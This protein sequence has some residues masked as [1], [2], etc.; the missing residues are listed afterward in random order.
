V[1]RPDCPYAPFISS[2]RIKC[3]LTG[4]AY[5]DGIRQFPFIDFSMVASQTPI[6]LSSLVVIV[7]FIYLHPFPNGTPVSLASLSLSMIFLPG[8]SPS[9]DFFSAARLSLIN[10]TG[11]WMRL[12][13]FRL[14]Y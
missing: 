10:F 4:E 3:H 9:F 6:S 14:G 1:S 7:G 5:G 11:F 12:L 13:P 8:L 2:F